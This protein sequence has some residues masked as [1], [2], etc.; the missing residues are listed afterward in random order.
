MGILEILGMAG[1]FLGVAK[2]IL[3]ALNLGELMGK[4]IF[5]VEELIPGPG[6]G[7]ERK[8]KYMELMLQALEEEGALKGV[9][10]SKRAEI[11]EGISE[12]VDALVKTF[13]A[14][15]LFDE[16]MNITDEDIKSITSQGGE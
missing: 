10:E 12:S 1:A 14:S 2:P 6:R 16:R 13:K 9:P 3:K 8:P 11:M 4:L 5:Y 7:A 15:G